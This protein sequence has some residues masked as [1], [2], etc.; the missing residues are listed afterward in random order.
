MRSWLT[1]V[2]ALL[3]QL[4]TLGPLGRIPFAPGTWG[5]LAA[6]LAAPWLFAPLP[7]IWKV[8]ILIALFLLGAWTAG[9]A[10]QILGQKDPGSVVVD[11][12]AGQLLVFA[13]CSQASPWQLAAGFVLF[14]ATD[15]LKPWPVGASE[16]WLPAGFGVMLDD[17]LAGAYAGI[18]LLLLQFLQ[19]SI[20]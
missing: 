3:L 18:I 14:R 4:A 13:I 9:R 11:E 5:S 7:W 17:I 10:E 6:V 19:R 16:A 15:I 8:I 2:D 20:S 1:R 12:F